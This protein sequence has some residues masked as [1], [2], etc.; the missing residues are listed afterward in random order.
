MLISYIINTYLSLSLSIY[1]YIYIYIGAV[2]IRRDQAL[3]GFGSRVAPDSRCFRL[4]GSQLAA[5][6]KV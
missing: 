3:R 4:S 1:I 2:R 6:H 5:L